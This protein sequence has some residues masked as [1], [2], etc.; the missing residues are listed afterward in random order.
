MELLARTHEPK[1]NP[2]PPAPGQFFKISGPETIIPGLILSLSGHRQPLL[3]GNGRDCLLNQ[4]Q[5]L[6]PGRVLILIELSLADVSK[7]RHLYCLSKLTW[8]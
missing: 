7:E 2:P 8:I 5:L 3:F 4:I 6:A 1:L